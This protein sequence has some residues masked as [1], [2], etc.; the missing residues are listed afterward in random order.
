MAD[1]GGAS[2]GETGAEQEQAAVAAAQAQDY[3]DRWVPVQDYYIQRAQDLGSMK[4][5]AMG[6]AAGD[7]AGQF[8]AVQPHVEALLD[9]REAG[10]GSGRQVMGL[11]DLSDAQA[12]S[13]GTGLAAMSGAVMNHYEQGLADIVAMGRGEQSSADAGFGALA[14]DSAAQARSDAQVAAADAAGT[15]EAI[16]SAMGLGGGYALRGLMGPGAGASVAAAGGG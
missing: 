11:A 13:L 1:G 14:Q 16:G 3:F 2:V 5:E 6:A 12:Q 15:G 7:A 9:R 4:N 10:V 8:A